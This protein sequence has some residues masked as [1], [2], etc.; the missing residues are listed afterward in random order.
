MG[1]GRLC[2]RLFSVWV[3]GKIYVIFSLFYQ[4]KSPSSRKFVISL[5]VSVKTSPLQWF[6]LFVNLRPVV[7]WMILPQKMWVGLACDGGLPWLYYRTDTKYSISILTWINRKDLFARKNVISSRKS[8][9]G[10]PVALITE[11]CGGYWR[12]FNVVWSND[13]PRI[14]GS[15][16]S[17]GGNDQ[18][19]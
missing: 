5:H 14:R 9:G 18:L 8:K 7:G 13:Y 17:S 12:S 1:T 11:I 19:P 3:S 10:I 16:E 4:I 2:P 6:G 15:L